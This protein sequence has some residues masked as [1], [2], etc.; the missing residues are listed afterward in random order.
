MLTDQQR[1]Q[2]DTAAGNGGVS[3]PV[4]DLAEGPHAGV[5]HL[6]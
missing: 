4:G 6:V 1:L 2:T 3:A 5:C